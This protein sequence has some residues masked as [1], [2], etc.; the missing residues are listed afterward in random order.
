MCIAMLA[1]RITTLTV[2]T[3]CCYAPVL[4]TRRLKNSAATNAA[5]ELQLTGLVRKVFAAEMDQRTLNV[6]KNVDEKNKNANCAN[7]QLL[8]PGFAS[9]LLSCF[10]IIN[11]SCKFNN[12]SFCKVIF[13]SEA[14]QELN[15]KLLQLSQ[16]FFSL[17]FVALL[18]TDLRACC[19]SNT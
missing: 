18:Q 2:Q 6:Y 14:P 7:F 11:G 1:K 10:S 9:G 3:F 13:I 12:A 15:N 8:H 16:S 5:T 4:Q 19:I 17:V